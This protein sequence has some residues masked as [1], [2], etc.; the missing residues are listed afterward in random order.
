MTADMAK[1][2]LKCIA[3]P[4][5]RMGRFKMQQHHHQ[6]GTATHEIDLDPSRFSGYFHLLPPGESSSKMV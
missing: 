3:N 1:E 6:N 4:D 5:S 2:V